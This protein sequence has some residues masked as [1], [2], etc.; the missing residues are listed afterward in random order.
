MAEDS[1][2]KERMTLL[3]RFRNQPLRRKMMLVLLVA[4]LIIALTVLVVAYIFSNTMSTIG[5][6]YQSNADLEHFLTQL[7]GMETAMET[8]VQ[9]RT[10]E[11]VDRFY[12]YQALVEA[13]LQTLA[14]HPSTNSV[15]QKE[16]N[17]R[18]LAESYC[19]LSGLAVVSRRAN[20]TSNL[21]Y[22]TNRTLQCFTFLT[23]EIS[24]LNMLYFRSNADD[25]EKNRANT[26]L[27]LR[28]SMFLMLLLF[29]TAVVFLYVNIRRMTMPLKNISDIA[30][31]VADRDFD[32]PLFNSTSRD[33]IGNICRAF[34]SMIISIRS[35]IDAIWDKAMKEN[36]LREK[37]LEIRA[38][39]TDAHLRALQDQIKPHFLFNTL[40][41]GAGLAML[42][43]ADK[44]C[45]FLE[46][47]ADFLRYII[48]NP[49]RD[50][51]IGDELKM[52]DSYIYIMKVRFNNRYEFVKDVDET[53]LSKRMPNM[54]LQPLIDNCMRHGLHDKTEDARI[55]LVV[56]KVE[57][58]V[59]ITI[60]DNGCG[61]P[62]SVKEKILHAVKNGGNVIVKPDEIG[63]SEHISTGLVNVIA[64]M[65]YYFNREDVF[66]ILP[67]PNGYGTMFF[68]KMPDV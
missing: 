65:N 26:T 20:N 13:T 57:G 47:V 36:E 41:T 42:E 28:F 60:T 52:V 2:K 53:V 11:S 30:Q 40:N 15:F 63:R 21:E 6:T 19:S 61:F 43:G 17:I 3:Q 4:C 50:S 35:Y 39:Y 25:Y 8:Y 51:T 62:D 55:E 54:V 68:I 10:F 34:D 27:L 45:L 7:S 31:R 14:D 44:T 46:Q 49:G 23:D 12:H 64:R 67:N 59:I 38:L 56:K 32:V 9:Y 48:K 22:Y 66:S 58:D 5:D 16:Y 33:E 29:F 18:Q 37:E 1:G 24:S